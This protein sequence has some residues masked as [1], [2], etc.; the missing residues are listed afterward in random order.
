MNELMSEILENVEIS[1]GR[2]EDVSMFNNDFN[3][4]WAL[5]LNN[6]QSA[7]TLDKRIESDVLFDSH[8]KL[9]DLIDAIQKQ[10]KGL[11]PRIP[12]IEQVQECQGLLQAFIADYQK[13]FI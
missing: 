1:D 3:Q 2:K 13:I 4:I 11:E 7:M 10:T 5:I 6:H 8:K 9:F 12:T